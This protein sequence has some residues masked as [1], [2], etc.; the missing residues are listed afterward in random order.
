MRQLP[1]PFH[2]TV[3]NLTEHSQIQAGADQDSNPGSGAVVLSLWAA[4]PLEEGRGLK[5]LFHRGGPRPSKTMNIYIAIH[6]NS[7]ITVMK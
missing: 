1:I 5:Q 7:R 6:N 3:R 2:S 4:T